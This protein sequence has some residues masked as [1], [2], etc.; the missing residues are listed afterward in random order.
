M[1]KKLVRVLSLTLAMATSFS[2]LAGC[3]DPETS[4]DS[5]PHL[6]PAESGNPTPDDFPQRRECGRPYPH[7]GGI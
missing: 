2:V 6:L 1:N 5:G 7:H 4:S 3:K